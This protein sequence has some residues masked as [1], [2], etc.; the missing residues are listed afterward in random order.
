MD[1]HKKKL[2][3]PISVVI[4]LVLFNVRIGI[5]L[6]TSPF[7]T[8]VIVIGSLLPLIITSII[9]AIMFGRIGEIIRIESSFDFGG[10]AILVAETN[11]VN[12][13]ILAAVLEKT[14]ISIDF[15]ENGREALSMF[16]ENPDKYCLIFMDVLMPDMDGYEASRAIRAIGSERAKSIPIIGVIDKTTRADIDSYLAAGMNDHVERLFDPDK[17]CIMIKKRALFFNKAGDLREMNEIEH[18]IV[19]NESLALGNEGLDAQRH[20]LF[21][22]LSALVSTDETEAAKM[23]KPFA[24]MDSLEFLAHLSNE[25]FNEEEALMLKSHYSDLKNHKH[26]HDDF[27]NTIDDLVHR[28]NQDGSSTELSNEINKVVIRWLTNHIMQEDK[29]IAAHIRLQSKKQEA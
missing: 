7:P 15:A 9:I 3:L 14:R 12:R 20:Q 11:V 26:L 22:L 23:I 8:T 2:I 16:K 4:A 18:G 28:F 6:L 13:E 5:I 19:W 1:K 21:E 29:K 24:V 27:K 17:L 10:L 25:Y